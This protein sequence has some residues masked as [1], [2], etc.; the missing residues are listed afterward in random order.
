M[1]NSSITF[2]VSSSTVSC[3]CAANSS[4]VAETEILIS[5]DSSSTVPCTVKPNCS[6]SSITFWVASSIDNPTNSSLEINNL[7]SSFNPLTATTTLPSPI[8]SST[9]GF[10][11]IVTYPWP[12]SG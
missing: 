10:V 7:P 1:F 2:A 12:S 3:R 9:L 6:V 5:W 8:T 4:L 11:S